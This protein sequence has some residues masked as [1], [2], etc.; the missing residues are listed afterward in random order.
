MLAF[1]GDAGDS[2][3]VIMDAV[4]WGVAGV[5]ACECKT[6]EPAMELRF[7]NLRLIFL[8]AQA[9]LFDFSVS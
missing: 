5:L 1:P 3:G 7:G 6:L 9:P 8:F 4:E 2:R